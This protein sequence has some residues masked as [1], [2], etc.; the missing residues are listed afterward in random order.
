[1][2]ASVFKS[3]LA[4]IKQYM[5]ENLHD[6]VLH[7]ISD[8]MWTISQHLKPD[9]KGLS[10]GLL[11]EEVVFE[12]LQHALNDFSHFHDQQSD[13]IILGNMLSFKKLTGKSCLALNWSKNATPNSA[14]LQ[15]EHPILVL[16]MKEGKWWRNRPD[17]DRH[18][19]M[20]FFLLNPLHCNEHILLKSNN[21]TDS[22]IDHWDLYKAITDAMDQDLVIE[23]PPPCTQRFS[24]SFNTGFREMTPSAEKWATLP[25][26]KSSPRFIDLFCGVGG[27]HVALSAVG[28]RCV[29]ACDIDAACREN[30]LQNWG[31]DPDQDIR[32]VREADIPPFDIL[33]AGF[34]CQPFS[35]AGDQAG[36][37]D[38]TK[39]NLFFEILRIMAH[40]RPEACILENVKNI[41]THNKGDTWVTIRTHLRELGYSVHDQPVILSPL[42]FGVPQSRERA[43]IVARRQASPLPPFPRPALTK[44]SIESVLDKEQKRTRVFKLTGRHHEAGVIW[45]EFCQILTQN[46]ATIPRFPLW[47]DEWDKQRAPDD[48]FYVK[49]KNWIDRNHAFYKEHHSILHPWLAK[50]REHAMWTGALRKLEWQC[51]ETSLKQSLWTFRG[52]GIRVRNLD[53]SPT[54]VAISMIP[55]YGPEWR[56][57]TPRE[58]CRLQAFPDSYHYHPKQYSKQMGNAVNVKVVQH[59]AEWLL[60]VNQQEECEIAPDKTAPVKEIY[61]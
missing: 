36:F 18:I 31:V 52:S 27:F 28:G 58:V 56:K 57:L 44:T 34:P 50:S 3:D 43:F 33:C 8:K 54:L 23:L 5:Q 37:A 15:F 35:K 11:I 49:Y 25:F 42:Q 24:Y 10:G 20:G 16:N 47:T 2:T 55:V 9:G 38:K 53:Y 6:D 41:V 19:P 40:H 60:N 30:Y 26:D 32:T 7:E 39:G 46:G 29:F 17:F 14:A 13:C 12:I 61:D 51:N 59:V 4:S 45:E 1:M 48:A 21:K 22:L